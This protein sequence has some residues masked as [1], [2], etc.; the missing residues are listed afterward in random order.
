MRSVS[1]VIVFLWPHAPHY[2]TGPGDDRQ[3]RIRRHAIGRNGKRPAFKDKAK[4]D[5]LIQRPV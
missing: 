5:G 4:L 2:I 3:A 1:V